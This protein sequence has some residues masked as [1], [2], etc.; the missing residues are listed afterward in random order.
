MKIG[1]ILRQFR[2]VGMEPETLAVVANSSWTLARLKHATPKNA[3]PDDCALLAIIPEP[4]T[5][6][7]RQMMFATRHATEEVVA[8]SLLASA[9]FAQERMKQLGSLLADTREHLALLAQTC[10]QAI[11]EELVPPRM[12]KDALA[13]AHRT[14]TPVENDGAEIG[15]PAPQ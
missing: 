8:D 6:V 9:L 2:V 11:N 13:L 3:D 7:H 14:S 1:H 15:H 5:Q 12:V 10:V 4:D